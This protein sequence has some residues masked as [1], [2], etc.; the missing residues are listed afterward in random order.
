MV[1]KREL[2]E[3]KLLILRSSPKLGE[4]SQSDGGVCDTA[5]LLDTRP[6]PLPLLRSSVTSSRAEEDYTRSLSVNGH[7]LCKTR[8]SSRSAFGSRHWSPFRKERGSISE[9]L[10]SY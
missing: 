8:A 9:S 7:H 3:N 10:N 6:H 5:M 1:I 4:V 2:D